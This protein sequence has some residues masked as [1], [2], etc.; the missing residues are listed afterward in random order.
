MRE[1][2]EQS[3]L[4]RNTVLNEKWRKVV[5]TDSTAGALTLTA[6]ML[7]GGI[8][9]RDPNGS[10]RS[11]V[12]PTAALLVAAMPWLQPQDFFEFTILNNADAAETITMTLGTGATFGAAQATHTIAQNGKQS[13]WIQISAIASGSEAY[14]IYEK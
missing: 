6:A 8:L 2:I 10:N 4:D 14:V 5:T 3:R 1:N 9:V 11:D 13:Y 12:F 7:R